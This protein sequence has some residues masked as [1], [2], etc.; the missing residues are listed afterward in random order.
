[1]INNNYEIFVVL[2]LVQLDE[3]SYSDKQNLYLSE[4]FNLYPSEIFIF[5]IRIIFVSNLFSIS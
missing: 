3:C 5:F 4:I 1:M 2:N